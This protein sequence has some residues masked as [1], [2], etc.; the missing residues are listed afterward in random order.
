MSRIEAI[1]GSRIAHD[2]RPFSDCDILLAVVPQS[3]V[4]ARL[5]ANES[6]QHDYHKERY[7]EAE[8]AEVLRQ[9]HPRK[10][11]HRPVPEQVGQARP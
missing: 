2:V 4:F 8:F 9:P 6:E 7:Q 1:D 11:I 10:G 5:K 3:A